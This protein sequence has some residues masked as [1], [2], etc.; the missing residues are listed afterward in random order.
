RAG[1]YGYGSIRLVLRE[2][3]YYLDSNEVPIVPFPTPSPGAPLQTSP[4]PHFQ[5]REIAQLTADFNS[6]LSRVYSI[7]IG[8]IVKEKHTIEPFVR[9]NWVPLVDQT[10]IPIYDAVDRIN[11]R[12]LV[13][14]GVVS[15][16]L[17]K[18]GESAP[19]ATVPVEGESGNQASAELGTG[20]PANTGPSLVVDQASRIRELARAYV[21]QSYEISHPFV[22][23]TTSGNETA[24]LSALDAGLR[25]TPVPFLGI[26]GRGIWSFTERKLLYAEAGLNLFDPR[27]VIGPEDLFLASLRPVNSASLFYQFNS[28]GTVENVNLA[29]TYRVTNNVA[30]AYLGRFDAIEDRFLENWVGFRLI[31]ACDCWVVDFALV[32]RVNPDEREFRV[33]FSL[34]GLGSFGQQPFGQR[35]D[36]FGRVQATGSDLGGV[37]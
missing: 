12:N 34:V 15:R 14:Y 35:N 21:Q 26:Q 31:S 9:Y 18:F 3:A 7:P 22:V 20:P 30:F 27:P 13:T 24:N 32:D 17:G 4:V 28:G 33:L 37:Y 1:P 6:E 10:E 11:A 29:A 23:S 16:L 36:G 25:L 19:P 5:H 2:T 8:D